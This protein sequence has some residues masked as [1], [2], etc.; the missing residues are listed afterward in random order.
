MTT[1]STRHADPDANPY[2]E[3]PP[4]DFDPVADLSEDEAAEQ[5]ALLRAAVREHDHR[6]YVEADPLVSD[7]A[8][9]ALFARLADL[10]SAF[11]LPT[12]NSP[13]RRI[14]G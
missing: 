1:S 12:E 9:D 10:E 2:V 4:T 11:D 8:Y 13:T 7:E 3:A 5:A 6:Y 14:G